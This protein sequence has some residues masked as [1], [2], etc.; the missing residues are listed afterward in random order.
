MALF[1]SNMLWLR[2]L[3]STLLNSGAGINTILHKI[4]EAIE[5]GYKPRN[6]GEDAYDLALLVYRLG[7][8]NLLYALNQRLALPSLHSVIRNHFSLVT[9]TPTIGP[10]T[11]D[12]IAANIRGVIVEP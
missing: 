4:E 10:I 6:Y 7:G 11:P 1:Q 12:V 8:A 5:H 9:I 3:L 2:Q